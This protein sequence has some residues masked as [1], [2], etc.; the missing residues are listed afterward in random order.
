MQL[1]FSSPVI[2]ALRS[3]GT[4]LGTTIAVLIYILTALVPVALLLL[5]LRWM[6]HRLGLRV[7]FWKAKA[8]TADRQ[9]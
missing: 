9:A 1:G 8:D 6:L 4:T 2:T 7:R 5:A 3:I